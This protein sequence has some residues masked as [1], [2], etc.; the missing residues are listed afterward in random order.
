MLILKINFLKINYFYIFLNKKYFKLPLLTI[1]IFLKTLNRSMI[2]T[3]PSQ[4]HEYM[5]KLPVKWYHHSPLEE[6]AGSVRFG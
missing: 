6:I 1:I 5:T 2:Q 4:K 3:D